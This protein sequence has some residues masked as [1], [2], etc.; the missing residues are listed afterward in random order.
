MR[1]VAGAAGAVAEVVADQD[2]ARAEA[3]DEDVGDEGL[4]RLRREGGVEA[5]HHRLGDAAALELAQLVAQRRDARRRRLGLASQPG[6]IVARIGLE[7]QHRRRQA[8]VRRLRDEQREHRLVAAMDAVEIADRQ[9]AVGGEA[10]MPQAAEDAHG[11]RLWAARLRRPGLLRAAPDSLRALGRRSVAPALLIG[12][13]AEVLDRGAQIALAVRRVRELAGR[14]AV[15]GRFVRRLQARC[16]RTR[17]RSRSAR[18]RDPSGGPG[19]R[20]SGRGTPW[21]GRAARRRRRRRSGCSPG[22]PGPLPAARSAPTAP[23]LARPP[24]RRRKRGDGGDVATIQHGPSIV[25]VDAPRPS[26]A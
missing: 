25:A 24:G 13:A 16:G 7:G 2:V 1:V 6:E 15:G 4:G 17:A 12:T 26:V 10:G 14:P 9:R 3:G 20:R 21:A 22:R 8:A 23:A 19:A 5:H 18:R 11:A